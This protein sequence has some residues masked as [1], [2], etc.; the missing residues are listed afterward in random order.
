MTENHSG[1]YKYYKMVLDIRKGI[2][3]VD[4]PGDVEKKKQVYNKI[5]CLTIQR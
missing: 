4:F 2:I 3:G 5:N 1:N